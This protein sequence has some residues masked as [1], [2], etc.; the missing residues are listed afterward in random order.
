MS[1]FIGNANDYDSE[2][3]V[4]IDF[5]DAVKLAAGGSTCDVYR[6]RWRRRDVLVKR[7]KEPFRSMPLYLDAMDKEYDIGVGLHHPSLPEYREFHRDYIVMDYVDGATLAELLQRRDPWLA[8]A[9]NV[10]RLLTEIVDVVDY[11]HRHNVV[12]CDIKADNIIV[13]ANTRNPVLI[14]FDKCYTDALN[15]TSGDPERYG[16][17]SAEAGSTAIDFHAIGQLAEQLQHNA[18]QAALKAF[19]RACYH[20]DVDCDELR[21]LLATHPRRRRTVALR[22]AG[23]TVALAIFAGVAWYMTRGQTE[24]NSQPYPSSEPALPQPVV[25]D[26]LPIPVPTERAAETPVSQ[27]EQLDVARVR[28]AELDR[29]VGPVFDELM[30]DLD[31]L[32]ALKDNPNLTGEQL[33]DSIRR[34]SDRADECIT[35]AFATLNDMYPGLTE[36]EAW[37]TMAFSRAYTGYT[38]RAG[39]ELRAFGVEIE[40]RRERER[41]SNNID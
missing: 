23:G 36:R 35:E 24:A 6:T 34:H 15:D 5:D 37:R 20:P 41:L 33:I 31:R 30:A 26:T 22:I 10:R 17:P 38:R 7:L 28:A 1:R 40:R 13:T 27:E 32:N 9:K 19:I 14:D 2:M 29:R 18:P 3:R 39:P 21:Q 8:K 4:E 11:L 16:V 12:H 25:V